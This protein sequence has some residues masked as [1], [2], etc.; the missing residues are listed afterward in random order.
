[1]HVLSNNLTSHD[2][3]WGNGS[4]YQCRPLREGRKNNGH[5]VPTGS[6]QPVLRIT[7]VSGN[8]WQLNWNRPII[9]RY[10]HTRT[11]KLLG[12]PFFLSD[13]K[14]GNICLK[15]TPSFSVEIILI[16]SAVSTVD[17]QGLLSLTKR[18]YNSKLGSSHVGITIMCLPRMERAPLE[19]L[20]QAMSS[21]FPWSIRVTTSLPDSQS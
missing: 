20:K 1:M 17:A 5:N 11:C 14:A 19:W 7:R 10:L 21:H 16:P 8:V 12:N 15:E 13:W 3:R 9:I 6:R 4:S 18:N 2:F